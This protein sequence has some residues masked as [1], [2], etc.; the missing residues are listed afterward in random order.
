MVAV[1][2]G[3]A[4]S[5]RFTEKPFTTTTAFHGSIRYLTAPL[6]RL[7]SR[8]CRSL[9]RRGAAS[10]ESLRDTYR[11]ARRRGGSDSEI[12]ATALETATRRS[13]PENIP[14]TGNLADTWFEEPSGHTIAAFSVA[15]VISRRYGKTHRWVPDAA[16]GLAATIGLSIMSTL[17]HFPS[18][19]FLGAALRYS[20]S[21]FAV[22]R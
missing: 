16:Y 5:D 22:L 21:R 10:E 2:A 20:V 17:A 9:V 4:A 3:L 12:V 15:A 13:R 6:H 7:G 11:F 1:T 19:V 18:D 8:R 14:G